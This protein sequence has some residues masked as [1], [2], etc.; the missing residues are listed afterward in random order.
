MRRRT[1]G[2]RRRAD[3]SG[4]TLIIFA[5]ALALVI[6]PAIAVVIEGGNAYAHQRL[7]QNGADSIANAGATTIAERMGG[8]TVT[9][10]SVKSAMDALSTSNSLTNYAAYYTDVAGRPLDAAGAVTTAAG[11]ALVG[12]GSIPANTQGVHATANQQFKTSIANAIGMSQFTATTEAT[13][14]AG[15][16][17]GG[18]FLPVTFPVSMA[19]CDGTG[20]LTVNLDAP[21]RLSSPGSPHPIGQE[22]IVPLCKTGGGSFM[23]LDLD[24]TKSCY[25][26]VMNPSSIQFNDFPVDVPTDVGNDCAKK[27]EQ[28]TVDA[29][30][31]G[32]VVL[33]PICDGDCSTSSG[34]NATFHII[35]IAAFFLDYISYENNPNNSKCKA[36]TSPT[37]GT[38]LANIVGG[39]GSSSCAVGWFV[40]YIT[41]GPVG[42]GQIN[43]G[44]AIGVQLIK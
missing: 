38:P 28:A 21:W 23:I 19:N 18:A 6:I 1:S 22:W 35:R 41:S 31:Q 10:T 5:L 44:E 29:G 16:L 42:T 39:N 4:Q 15:A 30:L 8:A 43:N 27:V 2:T 14:V 25:Q 36:A 3:E 20:S 26:E 12:G 9:D 24:P 33:I 11:A 13:A 7:A 17:S 40:R 34:S 32:K 37:Y